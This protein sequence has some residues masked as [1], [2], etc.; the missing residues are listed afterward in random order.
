MNSPW[1]PLP[2]LGRIGR[3]WAVGILAVLCWGVGWLA[4]QQPPPADR[5][6]ST[7]EENLKLYKRFADEML[8]LAQRWEKSD[9]PEDRERAKVLRAALNLA[10][11]RGVENLYKEL[12]QG[13]SRPNP[14]SSDFET[15]LG[16]DARL[17]AALREILLTLTTE[18]EAERLRRQIAEMQKTLGELKQLK[19]DL[20]NVRART[21]NPR[22]DSDKIAKDQRDL[23][24]RTQDLANRL[25]GQE[26]KGT[27]GNAQAGKDD[28]AETKPESKPGE[29][30]P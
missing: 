4:A 1:S 30:A 7:E 8:R 10:E 26:G 19:R 27:S 12:I 2:V 3:G 9:N 6:K 15:L 5:L 13:L 14:T 25:G 23:A 22:S 20:E 16:K 21:E 17:L 28:R 18:D 11:Q 29:A 24:N